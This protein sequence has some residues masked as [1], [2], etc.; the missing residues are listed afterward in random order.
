MLR[1]IDINCDMGEG[2]GNDEA[3][4]PFITSANVACGFHAG[5]GETIRHTIEL[6]KLYHCRIGAHPSFRD[7]EFFGRRELHIP[8]DKLYAIVI[9]QIIKMDMIAREKGVKLHH[10]KPH[11]ALYNMAARDPA[12][13]RIIAQTVK[14][15]DES[16]VIYGLS[17]SHL[18]TEAKAMGLQTA[19]EAF[20]D[21]TYRDDGSLTPRTQ[22]HA[23]IEQEGECL[24][25]VMQMI[26]DGTVT[27]IT[28]RVIPIEV[29]TICIHG[30]QRKAVSFARAIS[31]ALHRK[32][33]N[34]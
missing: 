1:A 25:Q 11:G 9:E 33:M 17:G 27:T 8:P 2:M 13:A 15:F 3:L 6:A 12:I 16:L 28:G 24:Q 7:K 31:N 21:R 4:M 5:N 30:D 23:L 32:M 20:A 19:S 22:A 14:D 29:E 10:V 26:E 18:I 34:R